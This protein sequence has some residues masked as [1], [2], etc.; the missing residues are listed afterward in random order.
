MGFNLDPKILIAGGTV[1]LISCLPFNDGFFIFTRIAVFLSAA[2]GTFYL[3]Q[4][5]NNRWI[6]FALITILYN[7][8]VPVYLHSKELW[9]ILNLLT[10]IFFFW[11]YFQH[12]SSDQRFAKILFYASK[13]FAVCGILMIC[14]WLYMGLVTMGFLL[15]YN[16]D[17][18]I[19]NLILAILIIFAVPRIWNYIFFKKNKFWISGKYL[20]R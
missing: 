12:N 8:I 4:T 9:V 19:P 15:D 16:Q 7:P 17:E 6:V 20:D 11:T 5:N 2:Y 1:A 18:A 13:V 10:S 3:N 14:L